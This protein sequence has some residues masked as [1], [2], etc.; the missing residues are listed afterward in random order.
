MLLVGGAVGLGGALALGRVAGSLLYEMKGF[1]P[2]VFAM[3]AVVLAGVAAGAGYLPAR[4]AS[5]VDPI[6]ALRYE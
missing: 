5:K 2:I 4:K 1:D 3:A 6:R